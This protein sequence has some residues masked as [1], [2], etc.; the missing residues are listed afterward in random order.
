MGLGVFAEKFQL[1]GDGETFALLVLARHSCVQNGLSLAALC[2]RVVTDCACRS[3]C[4]D[5]VCVSTGV[6]GLL[7]RS[8]ASSKRKNARNASRS[9]GGKC[10][11]PVVTWIFGR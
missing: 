4:S 8:Q 1:R 2:R 3:P 11:P 5:S 10:F 7:L 6:T 9:S